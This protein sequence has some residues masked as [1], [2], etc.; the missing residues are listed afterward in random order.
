MTSV[1]CPLLSPPSS[2]S[3]FSWFGCFINGGTQIDAWLPKTASLLIVWVVPEVVQ[4]PHAKPTIIAMTAP[5]IRPQTPYLTFAAV[6][7]FIDKT[8]CTGIPDI[9]SD[10]TRV[11]R[12]TRGS[13]QTGAASSGSHALDSSRTTVH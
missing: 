8:S 9:T 11:D 7:S 2:L 4:P 5:Q 12:C 6:S 13:S 1:L 3:F 10:A